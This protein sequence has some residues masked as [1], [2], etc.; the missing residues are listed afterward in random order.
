MHRSA[1]GG[2]TSRVHPV[3]RP[4]GMPYV[5]CSDNTA[6]S[7]MMMV[8]STPAHAVVTP[9]TVP[10]WL[11]T[12]PPPDSSR[13]YLVTQTNTVRMEFLRKVFS[14][15]VV[16]LPCVGVG[17][18]AVAD[19]VFGFFVGFCLQPVDAAGVHVHRRRDVCTSGTRQEL[20]EIHANAAVAVCRHLCAAAHHLFHK[21]T[22]HACARAYS[23][24]PFR[25]FG[26]VG[27]GFFDTPF[28]LFPPPVEQPINV[29]M[30]LLFTL[31]MSFIIG[32][33]CA[34]F[35][36]TEV[37]L[38]LGTVTT[39]TLS[40]I[41]C[42]YLRC[43]V[44]PA[45]L[46]VPLTPSTLPDAT[47]SKKYE[48]AFTRTRGT[49]VIIVA[50]ALFVVLFGVAGSTTTNLAISASI[51]FVVSCFILIWTHR[52]VGGDKAGEFTIED[53][54]VV[55]RTCCVCLSVCMSVFMCLSVRVWRPFVSVF[56][57]VLVLRPVQSLTLYISFLSVFVV[58]L[59]L[60]ACDNE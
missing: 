19:G 17:V 20:R 13:P 2:S 12:C 10:V 30:L 54:V 38:S 42:P 55:V 33:V 34:H 6:I 1:S 43:C 23:L 8:G 36:F 44:V 24:L 41:I 26:G 21:Q 51:A 11:Q 59:S 53:Y 48:V 49:V 15:C 35:E 45:L 9:S 57:P 14:M 58:L 7:T 18:A 39:V 25:L 32:F 22:H 60:C 27:G 40:L 3:A 4:L 56:S 52:I 46:L 29:V 16:S 28:S 50:L 5:M 37:L 47:V 31:F